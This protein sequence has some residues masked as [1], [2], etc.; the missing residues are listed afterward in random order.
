[1]SDMKRRAF[2]S[3]L[4]TRRRGRSGCAQ[5]PA[6]VYTAPTLWVRRS[7]EV[8]ATDCNSRA[9]GL[10]RWFRVRRG[11]LSTCASISFEYSQHRAKWQDVAMAIERRRVQA[12]GAASVKKQGIGAIQPITE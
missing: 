12:R 2:I 9:P 8:A 1:M 10:R 4:G 11:L 7:G 6:I 5:Q 3:L